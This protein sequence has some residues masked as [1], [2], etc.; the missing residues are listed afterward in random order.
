MSDPAIL[1]LEDTQKTEYCIPL[2]LRDQQI[3]RACRRARERLEPSYASRPEPVAVVG[4][5]PSLADTIEEIRGYKHII[6]CS[7]A[8]RFLLERGIKPTW[9]VEVDPRPHKVGL[10]GPPC[11]E[12]TYLISSTCH[13]AV[14]D[15]LEGQKVVLWHVY[16]STEDGKRLLPRGEWAITGGSDVGMRSITIAAF[17]GFRDMHVFGVD[18]CARGAARHA[19]PHPNT[20]KEYNRVVHGGKEYLTT[21][22]MLE[23]AKQVFHEVAQLNGS[24]FT[25]HGEGL[26]QALALE[27]LP[28]DGRIPAGKTGIAYRQDI[29]ISATYAEQNRRLHE[30]RM[31]YGV[32]GGKHADMVK[33]LMD[34]VKPPVR[35][36]LD[37]GCGKG[38]LA[39]SLGFPIWEYDP[40]VPGKEEAPR[41]ADLVICTDVL[42]HVE[43][44]HLE[45]VLADLGRV[46]KR[47]AYLT[48]HTGP[49]GK[50]LSDGR[51]AHLVQQPWAW[52]KERLEKHLTIG[53]KWDKPPHLVIIAGPRQKQPEG[54][55]P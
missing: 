42:E 32:G 34:A 49:S 8:H 9:H 54:A 14:F 4:F 18:G 21:P 39:R 51:N 11:P 13:P 15:H 52:W 6:S 33:R 3:L 20:P 53:R 40:G 50:T 27:R 35:S 12:T 37:Y 46:T 38:L 29:L 36:V 45:A 5:G 22:A 16:D 1:R 24:R 19:G 41:P 7:G 48:I 10:M 43:P 31:D 28:P 25:F 2:W 23:A 30:E 47:I 55:N 44:E 17:L 26:V